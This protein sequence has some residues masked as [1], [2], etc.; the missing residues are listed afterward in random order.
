[1]TIILVHD[2][3]KTLMTNGLMHRQWTC[4]DVKEWIAKNERFCHRVSI[5]CGLMKKLLRHYCTGA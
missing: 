2:I 4:D 5:V 1:M 3:P